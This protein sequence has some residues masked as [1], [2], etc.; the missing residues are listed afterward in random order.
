MTNEYVKNCSISLAIKEMQIKITI[1]FFSHP[2]QIGNHYEKKQQML[3]KMQKKGNPYTL[4][5]EMKSSA[6]TM[7]NSMESPQKTKI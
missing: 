1:R 7:E 6:T 3:V 4:L 2:S 5:L